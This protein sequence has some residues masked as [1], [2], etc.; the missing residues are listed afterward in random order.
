[1][2]RI[3]FASNLD[4]LKTNIKVAEPPYSNSDSDIRDDPFTGD[5]IDSY[6]NP[7]DCIRHAH[8]TC[9]FTGQFDAPNDRGTKAP[10]LD[11]NALL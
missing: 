10:G 8:R 9:H 4:F 7:G 6:N 5:P 3:S 2:T 1:M 11:L